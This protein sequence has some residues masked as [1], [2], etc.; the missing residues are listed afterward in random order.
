VTVKHGGSGTTGLITTP[1]LAIGSTDTKVSTVLFQFSIHNVHYQK[2]AV[3]AGTTLA[4][5][6]IPIDTWGLYLFSINAAGTILC[7]AAAGNAAGYATEALAIAALPATPVNQA[8]I[9]YVTV[10]TK[11]GTTF[12][13][14]TDGLKGGASGNV[15]SETNYTNTTLIAPATTLLSIPWDF[16][17]GPLIVSLPGIIKS[18]YG[19]G[20]SVE[21]AASGSGGVTGTATLFGFAG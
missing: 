13:A 12:V 14:G 18:D 21:L 4:T 9:G 20:L 16:T 19:E 3:A 17:N 10:K 7:T 5:G 2:A 1:T 8:S 6:T 11:S 15:A